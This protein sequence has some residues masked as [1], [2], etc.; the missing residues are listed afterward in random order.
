MRLYDA[1]DVQDL[2]LRKYGSAAGLYAKLQK[3][4]AAASKRAATIKSRGA[5]AGK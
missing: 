5:G 4:A 2:C 1:A 3:N